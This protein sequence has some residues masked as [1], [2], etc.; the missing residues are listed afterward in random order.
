[1]HKKHYLLYYLW[2]LFLLVILGFGVWV[3]AQ[4]TT[5]SWTPWYEK[6]GDPILG[7]LLRFL[8]G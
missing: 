4:G 3:F 1:M 8:K 2:L 6:L 5:M 7:Q